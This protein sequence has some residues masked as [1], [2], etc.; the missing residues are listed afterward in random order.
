MLADI[1]GYITNFVPA[2]LVVKVGGPVPGVFQAIL[3][4][5]IVMFPS[6]K[7]LVAGRVRAVVVRFIA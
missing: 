5:D 4:D 2:D 7:V 3:V 1:L 6:A